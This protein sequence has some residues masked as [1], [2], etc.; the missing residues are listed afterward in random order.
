[1]RIHLGDAEFAEV[2]GTQNMDTH[3]INAFGKEEDFV[4]FYLSSKELIEFADS[5][6]YY[7]A[8]HISLPKEDASKAEETL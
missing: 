7:I 2:T 8:N 6:N 4:S 3:E 1:M 5:L